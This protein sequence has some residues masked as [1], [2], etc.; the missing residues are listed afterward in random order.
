M[1]RSRGNGICVSGCI[2][3]SMMVSCI[4]L[5]GHLVELSDLHCRSDSSKLNSINTSSAVVATAVMR[6]TICWRLQVYAGEAVLPMLI[7][8]YLM[9]DEDR[10]DLVQQMRIHV[11][12]LVCVVI[13][14]G[15]AYA[16]TATETGTA[17]RR[18]SILNWRFTEN[19][20]HQS[21]GHL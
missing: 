18:S 4:V 12:T 20:R 13:S 7:L 16:V 14:N 10:L 8:L 11:Q 2:V 21:N 19:D 6:H 9:I 17:E 5:V 1:R 3:M 15:S